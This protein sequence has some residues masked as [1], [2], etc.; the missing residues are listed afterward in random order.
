MLASH[1]L[2]GE[3]LAYSDVEL[4]A[5]RGAIAKIR[6]TLRPRFASLAERNG[7]YAIQGLIGSID[8]NGAVLNIVPKTR[9]GEDWLVSVLH[10]L[11]GSDRIEL[12]GKR[13]AGEAANRPDLIEVLAAIYAARLMSAIRRDG[14]ITVIRRIED[15]RAQLKGTLRV[16]KWARTAAWIPH[17]FPIIYPE[18]SLDN[19]YAQSLSHAAT[20]LRSACRSPVTKSQ[21]AACEQA[22]NTGQPPR[23]PV[24]GQA[25]PVRLPAQWAVYESAW[26]IAS[27][28]LRQ[29]SLLGAVGNRAGVSILIEAWPLLERLLERSLAAAASLAPSGTLMVAPKMVHDLLV[30]KVGSKG[31]SQQVVPDG[32]LLDGDRPLASFEAKYKRSDQS[33]WPPREDIFQAVATARAVGSPLAVLVYPDQFEPLIAD[34][35]VAGEAPQ[36]LAAVG[37]GLFSYVAG[38]GDEERGRRIL[39]LL[40]ACAP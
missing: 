20:L 32:L 17:Q 5:L 30:G 13:V 25:I 2:E 28:V 10:L 40:E 22:L 39:T 15:T 4:S 14:P 6:P 16:T 8:L 33:A 35:S 21:L 24:A 3:W 36:K 34:V 7:M 18:L 26:A 9:P 19:V 1:C 23:S 29:R 11:V 12:A 38:S 31:L 37:L 27:A